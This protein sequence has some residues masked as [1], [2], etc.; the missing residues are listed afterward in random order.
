AVRTG[1]GVGSGVGVNG[2]SVG[3]AVGVGVTNP[4]VTSNR[5]PTGVNASKGA[6]IKSARASNSTIRAITRRSIECY[7]LISAKI[8]A[9]HRIHSTR[10][11]A[12]NYM[13]PEINID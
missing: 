10:E 8:F 2:I 5:L 4:V 13:K 12:S 1:I 11:Y 3:V 7:T 9:S 6:V